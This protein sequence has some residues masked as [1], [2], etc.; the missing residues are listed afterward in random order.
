[1]TYPRNDY[2]KGNID[3]IDYAKPTEEANNFDLEGYINNL[4]E[5]EYEKKDYPINGTYEYKFN[6]YILTV[7]I[8][9]G[10]HAYELNPS[11]KIRVINSTSIDDS[12]DCREELCSGPKTNSWLS[13]DIISDNRLCIS[14]A[15]ISKKKYS[16]EG[17][18]FVPVKSKFKGV[19]YLD[20]YT[21]IAIKNSAKKH[22]INDNL[23][24]LLGKRMGRKILV[25]DQQGIGIGFKEESSNKELYLNIIDSIKLK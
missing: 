6:N 21:R 9:E 8:P 22:V 17:I 1:F 12:G 18:V 7:D 14:S 10:Y 5:I 16:C 3:D 25:S 15:E 23:T 19:S 11:E 24:A 13:A 4:P 20:W 2:V